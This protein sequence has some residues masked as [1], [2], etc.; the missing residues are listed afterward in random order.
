MFEWFKLLKEK[1]DIELARLGLMY[2]YARETTKLKQLFAIIET[3]E[4]CPS[5]APIRAE[6]DGFNEDLGIAIEVE[7]GRGGDQIF[8]DLWKFIL[9]DEIE[10]GVVIIPIESREG[11]DKLFRTTVRKFS[12]LEQK[13][14]GLGL[15]GL[16]VIGY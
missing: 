16:A 12:P 13:L 9:V 5:F 2:E 11:K 3:K 14:E 7:K 8:R 15:R 1:K 4:Q 10:Y 6:V